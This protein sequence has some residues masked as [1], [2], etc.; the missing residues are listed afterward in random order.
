VRLAR[1]SDHSVGL[2]VGELEELQGV[3]SQA[4]LARA[5]QTFQKRKRKEFL[6]QGVSMIDPESVYLSFD[7]VLARD[8]V[9][10][11]HVFFGPDVSLEEGVQVK[12]FSHL[13]GVRAEKGVIIGPFARLR[14][15][16]VLGEK[17]KIGNF[18]EVKKSTLGA[19]A[20]V[21]HLSYIGDASL[22]DKVNIGAGTITC[23]Y[24]GYK[25][26]KTVIEEG[27]FVGSNTALVAPVV[28]GKESMIGA[29]SVITQDVPADDIAVAR[30][31]QKNI[32]DGSKRFRSRHSK[33]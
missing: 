17:S 26:H 25:K 15:G 8:V 28:L 30:A 29:G 12:A 20:K 3:N 23:N 32:R 13:E 18:V 9:L 22:G 33:K 21:S 6:D 24:D 4:E 11:P 31:P 1:Q 5:E 14:P 19:H 27:V 7:T 2:E 10:E 16:T